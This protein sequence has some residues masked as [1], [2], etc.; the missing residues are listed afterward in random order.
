MIRN[1]FLS[2]SHKDKNF[3]DRLAADLEVSGADVWLDRREIKPGDS[4][5]DLVHKQIQR[6]TYLLAVLSPSFLSSRFAR[7]EL[8]EARMAQLSR[9]RIKVVPVLARKC[10]IPS[11]LTSIQYADFTTSYTFGLQALRRS[12]GLVSHPQAISF[13]NETGNVIL[14]KRGQI[15]CFEFERLIECEVPGTNN[16]LDLNIYSDTPPSNVAVR[17]GSTRIETLS[18]LYKLFTTLTSPLPLH[19]PVRRCMYYELHGVYGDPEDYW[20]YRMPASF[21][22]VRIR[23]VFPLNRLPKDVTSVFETDGVDY[24]GP[25][26]HK[27]RSKH[28]VTYSAFLES[29]MVRYRSVRFNW[30]W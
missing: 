15:A 3:V 5:V 23:I 8:N 4:I 21:D 7:Q 30:K 16:F 14:R 27:R 10:S 13:R 12:L 29:N 17:P 6:S 20:F 28:G 11:L 26:L 9:R 22:W 24:P 2:Y 1:I 19:K 18:G 25:R